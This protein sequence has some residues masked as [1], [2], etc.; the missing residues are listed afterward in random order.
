MFKIIEKTVAA[1]GVHK[2]VILS[3][4]IASAALPGQF[5]VVRLDEKG[6]RIP[7][8]IAETEPEKGVI[9]LFVQEAGKTTK[10]MCLLNP[11]DFI[12]DIAGPLGKPSEI[13]KYGTVICVGGGVGTAVIYPLAK[14]LKSAGNRLI[15]ILGARSKKFII[16]E[17]EMKSIA[18]E[19]Y[20]TTDDGSYGQKGLV[21]DVIKK[22]LSTG[23][24]TFN[25]V[26]AIGPIVMMRAVSDTTAVHGVRTIVS[27]NPI[28]VDGTGMCGSCRVTVGGVTKF[29]CVDGPDF[30]AHAVD[31]AELMNRS[32][33]FK[34]KE[35]LV[36][37][38]H[39]C[40]LEKDGR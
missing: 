26:Y 17:N 33:F 11:G 18:D 40:R 3:P 28:M 10:K 31:W 37:V 5:V 30:D 23:S 25:I 38:G 14:A 6:E 35:S 27:L 24:Q 39:K 2:F 4:E 7:L 9:T 34:D 19:F 1:E 22:L 36:V 12:S 32:K 20:I 29:A 15:V 21:T 16:L 13:E 8:T